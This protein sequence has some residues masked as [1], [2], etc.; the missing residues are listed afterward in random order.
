MPGDGALLAEMR[1]PIPIRLGSDPLAL[2]D[3]TAERLLQGRL[4]PDDAPPAYAGVAA[5][6]AAV[7]APARPDLLAGMAPVLAAFRVTAASRARTTR[8]GAVPVRRIRVTVAVLSLVG[9]LLAGGLAAAITGTGLPARAGRVAR[10]LLP[11][12]AGSSTQRSSTH[13]SAP[14]GDTCSAPTAPDLNQR[15]TEPGRTGR[16]AAGAEA[17]PATSRRHPACMACVERRRPGGPARVP[18]AARV[19]RG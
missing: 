15:R 7:S 4:D 11:G 1:R 19:P 9:T 16:G 5:L 17:V 8:R 13:P 12:P 6:L 3:A 2:D 10:T 14:A 18:R